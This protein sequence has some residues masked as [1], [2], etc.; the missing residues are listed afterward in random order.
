MVHVLEGTV[1]HLMKYTS[2]LSILCCV[3]KDTVFSRKKEKKEDPALQIQISRHS[4]LSRCCSWRLFL[5]RQILL[6]SQPLSVSSLCSLEMCSLFCLVVGKLFYSC[7]CRLLESLDV[8]EFFIIFE[9]F[10][11]GPASNSGWGGFES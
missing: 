9:T 11:E 7:C 5:I 6:S 10:S 8:C 4:P 2:A 1:N 3:T